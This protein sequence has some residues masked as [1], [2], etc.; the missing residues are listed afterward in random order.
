MRVGGEG[1]ADLNNNTIDYLVKAKLVGTVAGQEGGEADELKGLL[2]PVRIK[3]PF[4]SPDIDVQ[5]DEMLRAAGKAK[6]RAD[7][8]RQKA[9][10]EKQL[11]N[12]KAALEAAKQREIEK[13]QEVLEAKKKSERQKLKDRLLK[14]LTD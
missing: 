13:Q 14:K 12:E 2:I 5:L 11:A 9:E 1:K 10:L 7:I 6:L 8:D 3:G 4:E